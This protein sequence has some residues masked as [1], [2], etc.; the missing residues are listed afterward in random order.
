MHRAGNEKSETEPGEMVL[1]S[2][3]D[4]EKRAIESLRESDE[5]RTKLEE[6][7]GKL[8]EKNAKLQ[9]ELDGA[10]R[11]AQVDYGAEIRDW[12]GKFLSPFPA[13]VSLR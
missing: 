13:R 4:A 5:A 6:K 9:R 8:E 11:M 2:A 1:L 10:R 7:N 12:T 3:I